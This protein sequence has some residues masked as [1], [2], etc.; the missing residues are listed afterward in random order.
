[1]CPIKETK[2]VIA[3]DFVHFS[4]CIKHN[5]ESTENRIVS[6]MERDLF[7]ALGE[8]CLK[9]EELGEQ[10]PSAVVSALTLAT[11]VASNSLLQM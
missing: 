1:M 9:K 10:H 5:G 2:C 11:S 6:Q 4:R 3:E 7:N 8:L